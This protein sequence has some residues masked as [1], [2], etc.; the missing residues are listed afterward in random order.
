MFNVLGIFIGVSGLTFTW[1][2]AA[3][4]GAYA[5]IVRE[6][7]FAFPTGEQREAGRKKNICI[8]I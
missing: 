7:T 1:L 6:A 2:I 8:S 5:L 4:E 3:T